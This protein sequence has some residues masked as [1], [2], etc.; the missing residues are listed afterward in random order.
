MTLSN[1]DRL[2]SLANVL[3]SIE[4]DEANIAD[5]KAQVL[6]EIASIIGESAGPIEVNGKP[7]LIVTYSKRWNEALAREVLPDNLIAAISEPAV[8]SRKAKD[9]LP[10]ALYAQCQKS[11]DKPTIKA[12]P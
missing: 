6:T 10:P 1:D 4:R 2:E 7:V 9:V 5:V 8:S 3:R 11:S 12:A